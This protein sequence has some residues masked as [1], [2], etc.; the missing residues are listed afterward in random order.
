M[1]NS[2]KSILKARRYL[3]AMLESDAWKQGDRLP[4]IKQLAKNARVAKD[5]MQFAVSDFVKS[6]VLSAARGGG[7]YREPTAA[8]PVPAGK[9]SKWRQVYQ[10][11]LRD[12]VEKKGFSPLRPPLQSDLAKKYAASYPSVKKAL[13]ALVGSGALQRSGRRYHVPLPKR[14]ESTASILFISLGNEHTVYQFNLRI[15][16]FMSHVQRS[17]REAGVRFAMVGAGLGQSDYIFNYLPPQDKPFGVIVYTHGLPAELC[18]RLAHHLAQHHI[19]VAFFDEDGVFS[20]PESK[21]NKDHLKVF[22]IDDETAGEQVGEFLLQQGHR[23][24]AWIVNPVFRRERWTGRRQTGLI[25]AFV[26][27]GLKDAVLD[28]TGVDIFPAPI[29]PAAHGETAPEFGLIWTVFHDQFD[30]LRQRFSNAQN[31]RIVSTSYDTERIF[32]SEQLHHDL[33]TIVQ[34]VLPLRDITAW[35]GDNDETARLLLACATESA[36]PVPERISIIGFDDS[37]AAYENMITSYNFGI[38]ALADRCVQ[39]LLNPGHEYFINKGIIGQDGT[40][41]ERR[42]TRRQ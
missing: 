4:T 10:S 17:C 22:S 37:R 18:T 12:I 2:E 33:R 21:A 28:A 24:V 13:N 1:I 8:V 34:K 32:A 19:P 36:V 16:E 42:S 35:V 3:D 26:K 20:L 41:V 14:A 6:G 23:R 39:F 31:N 15:P 7:I 11:I 27:A 40:V 9:A 5:A 30:A 25:R 38:A 29:D